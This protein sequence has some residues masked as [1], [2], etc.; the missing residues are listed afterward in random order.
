[1]I[2]CRAG[3]G[4]NMPVDY[5]SSPDGNVEIPEASSPLWDDP[6]GVTAIVLAGQALRE[7]RS[8]VALHKAH[9]ATCPQ[10]EKFRKPR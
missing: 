8:V 10:A 6:R 3:T 4:K 9:H 7:R 1:M 2:W 5:E